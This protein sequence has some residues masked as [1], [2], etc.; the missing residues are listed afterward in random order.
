MRCGL[1]D[2][3][4]D[5]LPDKE[6]VRI[7]DLWVM[8]EKIPHANAVL[9][10]DARQGIARPNTVSDH[11]SGVCSLEYRFAALMTILNAGQTED[12]SVLGVPT[13]PMDTPV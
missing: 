9:A 3:N 11:E 5:N 10:G 13:F 7:S 8:L 6:P 2:G 4:L 12:C 1:L